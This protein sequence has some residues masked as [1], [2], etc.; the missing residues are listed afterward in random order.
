MGYRILHVNTAKNWRG[1]EQQAAYLVEGL[2]SRGHSNFVVCQPKS[3]L[4]EKMSFLK[5]PVFPLLMR[6]EWDL[7]AAIKLAKIMKKNNIQILHLHTAHA[8]TLGL[9]ASKFNSACK[10]VVSR[11]VV[12]PIRS[13]FKYKTGIDKIIAISK[14]VEKVLLEGGVDDGKIVIVYS[15]VDLKRFKEIRNN[16]YVYKEFNLNPDFPI[17]GIV[18]ALALNKDH[19]NFLYAAKM[20]KKNY[21]QA[22]FL[23]VG[24]GPLENE[25]KILIQKLR[26]EKEVVFTGFRKDCLEIISTFDVFVLSS[27]LEG[28]GS[29]LLEAM[30]LAKPI[31]A[32]RT[33][34]IPEVVLNGVSGILVP[35]KNSE[36]LADGILQLLKDNVLAKEMGIK[37]KERVEEFSKEK[38]VEKTEKIYKEIL[39]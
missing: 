10:V 16:D 31:V 4:E 23:I 20:V 3:V 24:E 32:T 33:G 26:L 9:F 11:R 35:P 1:G 19:H 34:G 25:L 21:P 14:Q 2:Q 15:S 30:A 17:V 22:K 5:I 13:Q 29:V 28:M 27:C 18:A 39:K 12:F 7:I 8:H 36:E 37:G 6:G 38:M